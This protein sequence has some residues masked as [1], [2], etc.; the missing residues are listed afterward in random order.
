[1]PEDCFK[2]TI[3]AHVSETPAAWRSLTLASWRLWLEW[4][5]N[6]QSSS[7]PDELVRALPIEIVIGAAQRLRVLGREYDVRPFHVRQWQERPNET[8]AF[9]DLGAREARDLDEPGLSQTGQL[10]FHAPAAHLPALLERA[11][12]WCARPS[13]AVGLGP[14]PSHWLNNLAHRRGPHWREAWRLLLVY[15]RALAEEQ[16]LAN[17]Q[18]VAPSG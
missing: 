7:L 14:W 17:A 1:M 13:T 3:M 6:S 8:L 15:E 18:Q 12:G 16:A 5:L 9:I 11:Q 10:L 2:E 4:W